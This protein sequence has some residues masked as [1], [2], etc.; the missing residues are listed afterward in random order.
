MEI[1]K[2]AVLHR[3]RYSSGLDTMQ[4]AVQRVC[5]IRQNTN[6]KEAMYMLRDWIADGSLKFWQVDS[7]PIMNEETGRVE[8]KKRQFIHTGL[9]ANGERLITDFDGLRERADLIGS[10]LP[11]KIKQVLDTSAT[12][13][14][15]A[16]PTLLTI[17]EDRKEAGKVMVPGANNLELRRFIN[18]MQCIRGAGKANCFAQPLK[19]ETRRTRTYPIGGGLTYQGDKSVCALIQA[20][21]G[22]KVS[23]DSLEFALSFYGGEYD[24]TLSKAHDIRSAGGAFFDDPAKYGIDAQAKHLCDVWAS[25]EALSQASRGEET[26]HF[27]RLDA[28]QSGYQGFGIMLGCLILCSYTCLTAGERRDF[29]K[30]ILGG[31]QCP[32]IFGEWGSKL[33]IRNLAKWFVMRI[34]YG[35]SVNS[36]RKAILLHNVDTEFAREKMFDAYGDLTL[37]GI[38]ALSGPRGDAHLNQDWGHIWKEVG[39]VPTEGNPLGNWRVVERGIKDL[40]A[41]MQDA[42]WGASPRLR[43]GMRKLRSAANACL[44]EGKVLEFTNFMGFQYKLFSAQPDWSAG[45][46]RFEFKLDG[47]RVSFHMPEIINGAQ[48]SMIGPDVM[49]CAWDPCTDQQSKLL[50]WDSGL[51]AEESITSDIH[52]AQG[53]LMEHVQLRKECTRQAYLDVAPTMVPIFQHILKQGGEEDNHGV[54]FD[55]NNIKEAEH[56]VG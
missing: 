52:D 37:A 35:A 4:M 33:F 55:I 40:C 48:A 49:H 28:A 56:F 30:F 54:T 23:G 43:D 38:K 17:L 11:P 16:N 44:E 46:K 15:R 47:Q 3:L 34:G 27:L 20:Q 6:A 10:G 14:F 45:T 2:E 9:H 41:Q 31:C 12:H 29:Y 53:S 42:V 24:L 21:T 36:L 22:C 51:S 7:L 50:F 39:G 8:H 1:N 25:A 18:E 5:Q 32:E 13:K 19:M 26:H